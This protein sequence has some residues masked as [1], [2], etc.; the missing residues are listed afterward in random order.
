[1]KDLSAV[2]LGLKN[3]GSVTFDGPKIEGGN[4][5]ADLHLRSLAQHAPAENRGATEKSCTEQCNGARF[6]NLRDLR[7]LIRHQAHGCEAATI[8]R[9]ADVFR[10]SH[11]T[12]R[13]ENLVVTK[14]D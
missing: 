1:M 11:L 3:L 13:G 7:E 5:E 2:L 6:R 10:C 4:L 14:L 9:Y 12:G 8:T